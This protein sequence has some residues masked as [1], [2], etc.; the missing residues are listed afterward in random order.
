M[1]ALEKTID[2]IFKTNPIYARGLVSHSGGEHRALRLGSEW[3]EVYRN[4]EVR[5]WSAGGTFD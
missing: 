3:Y 2:E 1:C 4:T 5:S